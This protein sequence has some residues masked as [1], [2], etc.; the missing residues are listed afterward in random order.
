[1]SVYFFFVYMVTPLLAATG[2]PISIYIY[3]DYIKSI[4]HHMRVTVV[5][6][7]CRSKNSQTPI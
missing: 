3:I 2:R 7:V 5:S 6:A 1:M 4:F